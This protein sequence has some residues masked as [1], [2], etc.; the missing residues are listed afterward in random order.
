VLLAENRGL[1]MMKFA[2]ALLIG[3]A[4]SAGVA[5]I[6]S[7]AEAASVDLS[8]YFNSDASTYT[9][10]D[11]YP[12]GGPLNI[13]GVH[14]DLGTF[15]GGLGVIYNG[16]PTTTK[17]TGLNITGSTVFTVINSAFGAAATTIGSISFID[18]ND[19]AYTFDLT[20][21]DNVRDHY[22]GFYNNVAPNVYGTA[23]FQSANP[24]LSFDRLD[25]QRFV[26]PALVTLKE[27]D[28]TDNGLGVGGG[29]P[30]LAA[31]TVAATPIPATLPL[32]AT[33]LA[34]LGGIGWRR[35]KAA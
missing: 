12:V 9:G 6:A 34:G 5:G 3:A 7:K 16:A 14:F 13:N 2:Y 15:A 24:A 23:T 29:S 22:N 4:V 1:I 35:R 20:E 31:I 28:F 19:I 25:A 17:I 33:A 32:L 10:G 21:G 27:I 18:T 30:F 11:A 26:L 8:S